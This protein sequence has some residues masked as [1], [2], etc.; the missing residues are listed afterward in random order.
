VVELGC[1]RRSQGSQEGIGSDLKLCVQERTIEIRESG[2]GWVS[3][4]GNDNILWIG[5]GRVDKWIK[6]WLW[7]SSMLLAHVLRCERVR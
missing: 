5:F 1:K 3:R 2:G 7:S 4:K 6:P